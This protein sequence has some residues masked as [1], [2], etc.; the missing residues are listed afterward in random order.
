MLLPSVPQVVLQAVHG[1]GIAQPVHA[2]SFSG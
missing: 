1:T 2:S